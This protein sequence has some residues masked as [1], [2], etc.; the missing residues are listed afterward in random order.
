M[1]HQ[2]KQLQWSKSYSACHI[3]LLSVC[4]IHTE[5]WVCM[6]GNILN[7]LIWHKHKTL[8]HKLLW[9]LCKHIPRTDTDR[10][11]CQRKALR[12]QVTV[13]NTDKYIYSILVKTSVCVSLVSWYA[14]QKLNCLSHTGSL[15]FTDTKQNSKCPF[16]F[17][18]FSTTLWKGPGGQREEL[19]SHSMLSTHIQKSYIMIVKPM[20]VIWQIPG[21]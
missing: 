17:G 13:S 5:N 19:R 9:G 16:L 14:L 2:D 3:S 10:H 1:W 6:R 7:T 12:W 15:S 8:W 4:A 11:L 18:Y 21:T 20:C